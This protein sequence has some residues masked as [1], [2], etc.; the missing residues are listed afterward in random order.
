MKISLNWLK[1]FIEITETPDELGQILTGTGLEVEDIEKIDSIPGGLEGFVVAE[2][3][4]C[5][6]FEVKDK[7]LSL[8]TVNIGEAE[9]ATIVCGAPNVSAGQRVIIAK[10][11]TTLYNKDGS[12]AFTIDKRKVYGHPS[13]GMIC[14][15]DEMGVGDSHDGILVVDT[16]L[17]NGTAAAQYFNI[18]SDYVFEI[19]LTPNRADAASHFGV[20]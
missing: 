14:A 12:A 17:P 18:E 7:K 20:A 1:E 3:I 2:V 11:G 13:E 15:E 4:T 10:V 16:N 6:R 8:T 5:E 19:G 9:L